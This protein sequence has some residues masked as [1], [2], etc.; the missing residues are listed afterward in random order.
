MS[1]TDRQWIYYRE[2]LRF[3]ILSLFLIMFSIWFYLV[4]IRIP[5]NSTALKIQVAYSNMD[6]LINLPDPIMNLYVKENSKVNKGDTLGLTVDNNSWEK[7]EA[8]ETTLNNT[9]NSFKLLESL[10]SIETNNKGIDKQITEIITHLKIREKIADNR[11]EPKTEKKQNS[12]RIDNTSQIKLTE[13]ELKRLQVLYAKKE[14]SIDKLLSVSNKLKALKSENGKVVI[15]TTQQKIKPLYKQKLQDSTLSQET[16]G[17]IDNLL[18]DIRIWK[19][20][21]FIISPYQGILIKDKNLKE[22][23]YLIKNTTILTNYYVESND[24]NSSD[25]LRGFVNLRDKSKVDVLAFKLDSSNRYFINKD[26]ILKDQYRFN[27][28]ARL[29]FIIP[30]Q[31]YYSS[32]KSKLCYK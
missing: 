24:T 13:A 4:F 7:I 19:S 30:G 6:S 25:T 2:N 17:L 12:T 1:I 22:N 9:S 21:Q 29:V 3:W 8:F 27:K 26:N 15:T 32:L 18:E 11:V 23:R 10:K 28:N 20:N 5:A 31:S 14:I 16:K